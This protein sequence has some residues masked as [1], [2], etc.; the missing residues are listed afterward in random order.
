MAPLPILELARAL[1]VVGKF[2]QFEKGVMTLEFT[3]HLPQC[4]CAEFY[5]FAKQRN[6]DGGREKELYL[7]LSPPT[8]NI[9]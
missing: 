2:K 8:I 9:Q 6:G 3:N 1:Q 7:L 5:N 4:T